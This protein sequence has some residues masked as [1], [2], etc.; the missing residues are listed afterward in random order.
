MYLRELN[1]YS[2]QED[3]EQKKM[4]FEQKQLQIHC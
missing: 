2:F 4:K 3:N 1:T